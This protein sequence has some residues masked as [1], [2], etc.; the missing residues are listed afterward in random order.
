MQTA[1]IGLQF[2]GGVGLRKT[3]TTLSQT[4]RDRMIFSD[5]TQ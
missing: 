5:S 1:E 3:P 2:W 4:D